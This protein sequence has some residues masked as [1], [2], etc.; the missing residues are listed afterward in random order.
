MRVE[1]DIT[2]QKLHAVA[3]VAQCRAAARCRSSAKVVLS[4]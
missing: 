1:R 2:D 4:K 3:I